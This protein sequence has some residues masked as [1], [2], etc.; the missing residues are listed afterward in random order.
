M[1]SGSTI[2]IRIYPAFS[3]AIGAVL[4][5]APLTPAGVTGLRRT[6]P[7]SGGVGPESTGLGPELIFFEA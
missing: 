1:Y 5:S 7:E 6:L 2:I 4:F 3:L